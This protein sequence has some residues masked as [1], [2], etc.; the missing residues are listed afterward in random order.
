MLVLYCY[1]QDCNA[2]CVRGTLYRVE[3]GKFIESCS[4]DDNDRG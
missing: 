1:S 2:Q 3:I 4:A